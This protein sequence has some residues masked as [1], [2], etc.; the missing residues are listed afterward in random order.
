VE[1]RRADWIE[2]EKDR[3]G[4]NRGIVLCLLSLTLSL[5]RK[6][7]ERLRAWEDGRKTEGSGRKRKKK[8]RNLEE[9]GLRGAGSFAA[10]GGA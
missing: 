6:G 10:M 9:A 2:P 4:A 5:D 7:L 3:G 1:R 8:D